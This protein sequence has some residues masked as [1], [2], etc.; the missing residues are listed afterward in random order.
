MRIIGQP[1]DYINSSRALQAFDQSQNLT[2][3]SRQLV[4]LNE[5]KLPL[6]QNQDSQQEPELRPTR[7]RNGDYIDDYDPRYLSPREMVNLS[8]ELYMAGIVNFDEY[9]TMAYQPELQP[10]YNQTVG[11]LTGEPAEPDRKR[12]FISYWEERLAFEQKYNTID[13]KDVAASQRIVDVLRAL[14]TEP[15]DFIV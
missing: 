5:P 12:D 4:P 8:Q 3:S 1:T 13:S 6:A 9:A 10:D 11:A 2:S 15:A 7:V 14:E